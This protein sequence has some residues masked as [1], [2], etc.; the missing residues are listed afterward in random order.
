MSPW[1]AGK[2]PDANTPQSPISIKRN[3][4]WIIIGLIGLIFLIFVLGPGIT[5]GK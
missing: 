3:W 4:G 5:F 2:A 1:S